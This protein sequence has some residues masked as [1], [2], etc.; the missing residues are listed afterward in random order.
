[1]LCKT[2]LLSDI[3]RWLIEE[4]DAKAVGGGQNNN[5]LPLDFDQQ[6]FIEAIGTA[7]PTIAQASVTAATIAQSSAIVNQGG[8]SNL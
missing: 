8:P 7:T 2:L 6:D 1:M 4:E 5:Q 3:C